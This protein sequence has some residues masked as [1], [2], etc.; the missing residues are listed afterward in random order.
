MLLVKSGLTL[1]NTMEICEHLG[2]QFYFSTFELIR[3][4]YQNIPKQVQIFQIILRSTA[5]KLPEAQKIPSGGAPL[6]VH[7]DHDR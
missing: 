6:D 2:Y 4:A 1:G 5:V 3:P 7:G